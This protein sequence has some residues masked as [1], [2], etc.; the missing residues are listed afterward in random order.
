[1]FNDLICPQCYKEGTFKIKDR[2]PDKFDP[3]QVT[4]YIQCECGLEEHATYDESPDALEVFK[5]LRDQISWD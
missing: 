3:Y 5:N 2:V 4:Y 1:M